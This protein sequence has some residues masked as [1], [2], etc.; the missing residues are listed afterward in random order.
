MKVIK[1]LP[2]SF[3][4]FPPKAAE[5]IQH[6]CEAALSLAQCKP[7]FFSITF[8]AGGSTR[9]GTMDAVQLLQ[10]KTSVHV[11]PHLACIGSTKAE[12]LETLM[13]YQALGVQRIVALRGDLPFGDVQTG[14]LQYASEL[15]AFIRQVLG[16]DIHLEVA[17]YP[18][19]HPQALSAHE[20]ILNL[21]RKYE[22]G[23]D[24]AITQYFFNPDAYFYYVDDCV[25]QGIHLPIV[26]GIMPITQ[27]NRLARFSDNCGAEIPRWIRKRLESLDDDL[28]SIQNFGLEVVYDLCQ[29]LI[30]GGAPGLHFYT[31]NKADVSLLLVN[32]LMGSSKTLL[33]PV[34]L[35]P[36]V[37]SSA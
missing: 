5:G 23:A 35:E 4:F 9:D 10:N 30:A 22:A 24:S 25:K 27:F 15:V 34:E 21:K 7:D 2:I 19:I 8:G 26:P 11:A 32:R 37:V 1:P 12:I 16:N 18:E 36:A 31:L 28:V 33:K 20:D 13:K 14:E 17:A 29:R 6:L 3:E